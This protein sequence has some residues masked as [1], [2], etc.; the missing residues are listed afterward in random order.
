MSS[1]SLI[2]LPNWM[3][4]GFRDSL[5]NSC[6]SVRCVY[7]WLGPWAGVHPLRRE[8]IINWLPR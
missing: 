4:P 3:K 6:L 5:T 8:I 2:L 1:Q 7:C